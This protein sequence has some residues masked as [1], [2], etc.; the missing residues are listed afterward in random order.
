MI[1]IPHSYLPL[2][3]GNAPSAM[4]AA[5]EKL[6]PYFE[7]ELSQLRRTSAEFAGRYQQNLA[8]GFA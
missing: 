8:S 4:D 3:I 7:Q 2:G 5:M 1:D 6:L